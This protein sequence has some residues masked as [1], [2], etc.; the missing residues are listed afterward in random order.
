VTDTYLSRQHLVRWGVTGIIGHLTSADATNYPRQT[1]VI[2][3]TRRGLEIGE[4]L[5]GIEREGESEGVILRAVTVADELLETR[6]QQHR[7]AAFSAC[8]QLLAERQIPI[9]LLDVEHLFDGQSLFFYFLG[10]PSPELDEI[11]ERL[12]ETYATQV[13]FHEFS[14]L[15]TEGC[16]PGCGTEEK[17][18]CGTAGCATCAVSS[19]CRVRPQ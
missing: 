12:A 1:R 4:V 10:E 8:E 5:V 15:L 6:L 11:T 3:R 7:D 13:R 16:G 14:T 2:C 19:A 18:G 9:T 17:A